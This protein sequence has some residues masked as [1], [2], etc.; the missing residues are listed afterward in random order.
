MCSVRLGVHLADVA[1][2]RCG[3]RSSRRGAAQTGAVRRVTLR[4]PVG[5]ACVLVGGLAVFV[6]RGRVSFG[7][8]VLALAVVVSGLIVMVGGGLVGS[9]GV[10]MMLAFGA[11][12]L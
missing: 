8:V 10:V 11:H 4:V 6:C 9:G 7:F 5:R 2:R 3:F 12:P 1:A